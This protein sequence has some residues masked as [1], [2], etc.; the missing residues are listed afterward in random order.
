MVLLSHP[1]AV[2]EVFWLDPAIAPAGESWEFLRPFAGSQSI[3]LLDGEDHLRE[4]RLLQRPFHGQRMRAFGPMV[5]ELATRELE[6]WS[7]RVA[8]LERMRRLTLEIILRV[9]FGTRGEQEVGQ[10]RVAIEATLEGARSMPR[11]LAMVL[12]RRDPGPW[13]PR[14]RF[15]VW[16]ASMVCFWSSSLGGPRGRT[17]SHCCRCCSTSATKTATHRRT[18]TSAISWSRC[19]WAGTTA[20]RPRWR[21]RLSASHVIR[22]QSPGGHHSRPGPARLRALSVGCHL[23]RV[24]SCSALFAQA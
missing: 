13:S 20:R 7:G 18:G 16:T 9:A 19:S 1:D 15:R 8:T 22:P 14:G 24:E 2:R 4:R 21:G 23:E 10:L 6:T 5:A 3:L 12:V 11:V 17:A